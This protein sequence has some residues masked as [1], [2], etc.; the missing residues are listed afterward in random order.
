[1]KKVL[2]LIGAIILLII[3]GT[4]TGYFKLDSFRQYWPKDKKILPESHE[5]IKVTSEESNIIDVVDQSI[6]SVVTVS[7]SKAT[8]SQDIFS[9]DPFNPSEPFQIQPGKEEVIE[10]NIGSGFIV[11]NDGLIVTNKHVVSDTKANYKVITN[12]GKVYKVAQIFRD[13]LNDLALVKSFTGIS[14]QLTGLT[15]DM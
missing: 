6:P 4:W 2:L 9:F 8:S 12:N 15:A 10:R 14:N 3:L 1:M 13:P 11:S 7:I 5:I